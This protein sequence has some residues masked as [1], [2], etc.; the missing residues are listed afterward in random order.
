MDRRAVY[1]LS[2]TDEL[3]QDPYTAESLRLVRLLDS[4]ARRKDTSIR[5]LEKSMGV[6]SSV[7]NKILKGKITLQFRHVL[8]ICDALGIGWKEFFATFYDLQEKVPG[9]ESERM[10]VLLLVRAGLITADKADA[11]LRGE[12]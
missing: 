2:M 7:F 8:M 12:D 10:T 1:S 6:G 5:S 11:L 9:S 3:S 4:I